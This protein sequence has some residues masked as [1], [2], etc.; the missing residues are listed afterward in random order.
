MTN[1]SRVRHLS[2]MCSKVLTLQL[3]TL[4]LHLPS[5]A[6]PFPNL[7]HLSLHNIDIE[8]ASYLPV[9]FGPKLVEIDFS[10]CTEEVICSLLGHLVQLCTDIRKI[11]APDIPADAVAALT[12]FRMLEA[13][14]FWNA[15]LLPS[16]ISHLASLHSLHTLNIC[17]PTLPAI[18]D[19]RTA[20][21]SLKKLNISQG[22]DYP[23]LHYVLRSI[24][25][26][27]L[28]ELAVTAFPKPGRATELLNDI[29]RF[30]RLQSLTISCYNSARDTHFYNLNTLYHLTT[31]HHLSVC[32]IR[33][34]LNNEIIPVFAKAWPHLQSLILLYGGPTLPAD[35]PGLTLEALSLFATHLPKLTLLNLRLDTRSVSGTIE[36]CARSMLPIWLSLEDSPLEE[37]TWP[38]VAAYISGV[39]PN[40]SVSDDILEN[41]AEEMGT[42]R[43]WRDIARMVPI[44]SKAR[45]DERARFG[46]VST[47]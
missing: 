42:E 30:P 45:E 46:L 24:T 47:V 40:A 34:T 6:S 17:I 27:E 32:G 10:F 43:Y 31:L 20:F 4:R 25:S 11:S 23:S 9:T 22:T 21:S 36:P 28:S 12:R 33:F 1:A 44:I 35:P 37:S 15:K 8:S 38:D 3:R 2:L 19:S 14:I 18:L 5:A 16:C 41:D 26:K 29:A 13:C 39:Y 7:G